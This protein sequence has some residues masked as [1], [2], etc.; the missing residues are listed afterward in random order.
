MLPLFLGL[1]A[2]VFT[3]CAAYGLGRL[4]A[5]RIHSNT[6]QFAIGSAVLSFIIFF[7]RVGYM[8]EP[9]GMTIVGSLSIA[10]GFIRSRTLKLQRLSLPPAVFIVL[11][12]FAS[13]LF[14]VRTRA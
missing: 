7:L 12:I 4:L 10:S 1:F 9:V 11:A 3:V 2:A 6:L 5:F 13:R 14:G 8:A